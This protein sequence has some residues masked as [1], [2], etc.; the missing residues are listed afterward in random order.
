MGTEDVKVTA[1]NMYKYTERL[2]L[3][4]VMTVSKFYMFARMRT[5]LLVTRSCYL[6]CN[7][8]RSLGMICM[9][10]ERISQHIRAFFKVR[11]FRS[12]LRMHI[13]LNVADAPYKR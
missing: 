5:S 8:S 11:Y 12:M 10:F 6:I 2:R 1:M 9:W 4:R 3:C 7:I 13:G